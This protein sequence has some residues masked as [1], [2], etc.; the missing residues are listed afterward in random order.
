MIGNGRLHGKFEQGAATGDDIAYI[1]PDMETTLYGKF[2][3]FVMKSAHESVVLEASCDEDGLVFISKYSETFGPEFYYQAPT[4][5]SFGAGP[6]G[7][8]DPYERKSVR[9]AQSS[10]PKSGEGV[11][12]KRDLPVGQCTCYYSGYLY[13]VGGQGSILHKSISAKKTFQIKFHPKTT[14]VS[15]SVYN[16]QN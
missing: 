16:G 4:N 3:N 9:I 13:N 15:S 11:F 8:V 7:V 10:I 5:E 14:F 2:E 1:Y 6:P 12:A